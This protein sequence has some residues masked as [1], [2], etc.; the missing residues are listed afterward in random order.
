MLRVNRKAANVQRV[1]SENVLDDADYDFS[2]D[3]NEACRGIV[4]FRAGAR[5]N[6]CSAIDLSELFGR[7]G[8]E[9]PN[10]LFVFSRLLAYLG[11]NSVGLPAFKGPNFLTRG[12]QAG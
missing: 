3:S 2:L 7:E 11:R 9:F 4:R 10:P 12:P 6:G 8:D 1:R 5:R